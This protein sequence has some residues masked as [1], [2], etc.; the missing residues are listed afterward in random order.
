MLDSQLLIQC[1]AL[2]AWGCITRAA[3]LQLEPPTVYPQYSLRLELFFAAALVVA[4]TGTP[5]VG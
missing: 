1:V 4:G 3:T 2:P 5:H